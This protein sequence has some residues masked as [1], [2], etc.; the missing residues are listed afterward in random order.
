[1]EKT[2]I[3]KNFK[4]LVIHDNYIVGARGYE[5]CKYDFDSKE[6]THQSRV[7]DKKYSLLSH[8]FLTR[9]FFRAEITNMYSLR[10]GSELCI[11]KKGI[12][13]REK[14]S[15]KFIKCFSV[16]RGSRPLNLC[17]LPNG[18][19]YFGEYFSNFKKAVVHIYVSKD[20]GE[21]WNVVYT[22]KEGEINH[23]HGLFYDKFTNNIWVVT[24]DREN[25]CIIGYTS[26]EFKTFII[27]LRGGQEFR[28]CNLFFYKDYIVYATDSQYIQ[29]TIKCINRA[30]LEITELFKIQ[31]SGIY[32]GQSNDFAFVS[33]TV[34]PSKVNLDKYSHLYV[35][36]NGKQWR[37]ID[38]YK[39][40][41]WHKS[42][43][44]FGSIQFPRYELKENHPFIVYSGRA[45]S[46]I[47]GKTVI[48]YL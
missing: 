18:N 23:I 2:E 17:V 10:D 11:V 41:N 36:S 16:P 20:N 28:S 12:F 31:G 3:I 39:K 42:A 7:C 48:K 35:S 8:F 9:R 25:E 15:N 19:I 4:A 27:L 44:Q 33:S 13:R 34:E 30:T 40:D 14:N 46:K 24:G 38:K 6:I 26:D 1:M 22:F 5:V 37:E 29:N 21:T 32:A 47:D 43:F 45:L